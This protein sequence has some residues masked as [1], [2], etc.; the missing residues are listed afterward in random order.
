MSDEGKRVGLSRVV[1]QNKADKIAIRRECV[2]KKGR[3]RIS[4][5]SSRFHP[6]PQTALDYTGIKFV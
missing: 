6:P 1:L 2:T 5:S 3:N 4:D